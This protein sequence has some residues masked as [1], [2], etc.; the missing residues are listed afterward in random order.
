MKPSVFLGLFHNYMHL[1]NAQNSFN[2][3]N[4]EAVSVGPP[5]QP[6]NCESNTATYAIST[7][8]TV[9]LC[10]SF[11]ISSQVLLY[12]LVCNEAYLCLLQGGLLVIGV[13][14]FICLLAFF[15]GSKPSFL[16]CWPSSWLEKS[17]YNACFPVT[18]GSEHQWR[19]QPV[20][21]SGCMNRISDGFLGHNGLPITHP[22][23]LLP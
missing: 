7:L 15:F 4:E 11:H 22:Y 16:S 3:A 1:S 5:H 10:N 9:T 17:A 23:W 8:Q 19:S 21:W 2:T 6:Q 12:V 14:C 18:Q 13:I 20:C